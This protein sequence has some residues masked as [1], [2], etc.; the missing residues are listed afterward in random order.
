MRWSAGA[1]LRLVSASSGAVQDGTHCIGCGFAVERTLAR[2]HLVQH[3]SECEQIAA[4]ICRVAAH[5]LGRH[6]T[7]GAYACARIALD[8]ACFGVTK[9]GRG[10][11]E[12]CP[13][14]IEQLYS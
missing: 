9:R 10:L 8:G 11:R 1:T 5:L 7:H 13:T 4:R 3:D 12:L 2:D 14:Q 6:V